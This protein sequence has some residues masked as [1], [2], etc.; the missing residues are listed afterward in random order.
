M[1]DSMAGPS[2]SES[3]RKRIVI[4]SVERDKQLREEEHQE[5]LEAELEKQKE[6]NNGK[7]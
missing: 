5:R 4:S 6:D 1:A 7:G 3:E 2:L